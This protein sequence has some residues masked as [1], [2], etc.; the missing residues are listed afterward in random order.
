[1]DVI[2]K[3]EPLEFTT[4]RE[5]LWRIVEEAHQYLHDW[6]HKEGAG[7]WNVYRGMDI[8]FYANSWYTA[9][10]ETRCT[11]CLAGLWYL[12]KLGLPL[13]LREERITTP[14]IANFLDTLRWADIEHSDIEQYLGVEVP[15]GIGNR[16]VGDKLGAHTYRSSNPKHILLFLEW[17]LE[18]KE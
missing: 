10:T 9:I 5:E 6:L 11:V 14:E 3:D 17:L 15:L 1:M 2:E 16:L 12:Q 4:P 18:Q 13:T 7:P 8:D